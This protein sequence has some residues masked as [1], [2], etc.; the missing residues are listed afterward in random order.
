MMSGTDLGTSKILVSAEI[1]KVEK[2]K[3]K[4]LGFTG[5]FAASWLVFISLA[6][7][8]APWLP[9]PGPKEAF[10]DVIEPNGNPP[11]KMGS[12]L[13]GLDGNG[14]DMLAQTIHGARVSLQIAFGAV[15]T[16][17]LSGTTCT[18]SQPS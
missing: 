6:A 12:H 8:L 16:L 18:S 2:E 15:L 10:L 3:R 7:L 1:V 17:P 13:L 5:I 11:F 4:R 14:H 9:I